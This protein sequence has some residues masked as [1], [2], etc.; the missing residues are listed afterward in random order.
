MGVQKLVAGNAERRVSAARLWTAAARRRF[1]F[2]EERSAK[3]RNALG[4]R[5]ALGCLAGQL[6][7]CASDPGRRE[8]RRRAARS[9]KAGATL[10]T[11]ILL[12]HWTHI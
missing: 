6:G 1:A 9:P 3:S 4:G 2:A 11:T 8:K 7:I 12:I 5:K 10:G